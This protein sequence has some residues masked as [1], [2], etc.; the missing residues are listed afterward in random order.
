[1]TTAENSV[2]EPRKLKT[3]PQTPYKARA[4]GTRES[5][6][7]PIQKTSYGRGDLLLLP[8]NV[9]CVLYQPVSNVTL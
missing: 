5:P 6:P 1:M 4:F 7:S 2:S 8:V 9:T 3:F